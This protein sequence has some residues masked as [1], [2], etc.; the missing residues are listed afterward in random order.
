VT[1]VYTNVD[2]YETNAGAE[3]G[4]ALWQ[5]YDERAPLGIGQ[6]GGGSLAYSSGPVQAAPVG[7]GSF[8]FF[9]GYRASNIAPVYGLDEQFTEGRYEA[10]VI[11]WAGRLTEATKLA[12][13][14]ARK[15]YTRIKLARAGRLHA[16]PVKLPPTQQP[17]G[18]PDITKLA[19]Q[20]SDFGL[21][22]DPTSAY[23]FVPA[24]DPTALL[25]YYVTICSEGQQQGTCEASQDIEWCPTA[26]QASFMAD[27]WAT[28]TAT[29]DDGQY[30]SPVNLSG[31]GDGARGFLGSDSGVVVLLSGK[32]M[33][34][35]QFP[36]AS[37]SDVQTL[38]QT[39]ANK[40]NSA[41]LGS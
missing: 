21:T 35:I 5:S 23:Y 29:Y 32:L 12:Q 40:I 4:L 34:F 36:A 41:G 1:E 39:A 10:D 2:Q 16:Q 17:E 11:V 30:F 33:E 25:G 3:G 20:S 13:S 31:V 6:S 9:V 38:A 19:L 15:L 18:L 28:Y 24:L 22:G 27:F 14:L 37:A 8:A 7:S 26:N